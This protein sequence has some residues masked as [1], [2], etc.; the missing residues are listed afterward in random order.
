MAHWPALVCV[1]TA[2]RKSV[3]A[4]VRGLGPHP[5]LEAVHCP[6]CFMEF[7]LCV[8]VSY[9][10]YRGSDSLTRCRPVVEFYRFCTRILQ[11]HLASDLIAGPFSEW[12]WCESATVHLFHESLV[13]GTLVLDTFELSAGST[14]VSLCARMQRAAARS[15]SPHT[16]HH[17]RSED[18][19]AV[20]RTA[21]RAAP[22]SALLSPAAQPHSTQTAK[23]LASSAM[24]CAYF[25]GLTGDRTC[26]ACL[27]GGVLSRV[28]L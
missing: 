5:H 23:Q 28:G 11:R 25:S 13:H 9:L 4:G 22:A 15:S 6:L 3:P 12:I 7:A 19:E 20:T 27:A 10:K 21:G 18:D 17:T 16:R 24:W 26:A 14:L 2:R 8:Q 1:L